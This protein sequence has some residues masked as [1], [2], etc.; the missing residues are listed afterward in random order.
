MIN[1]D[2]LIASGDAERLIVHL[3]DLARLQAIAGGETPA[4]DDSGWSIVDVCLECLNANKVVIGIA[5][6]E[7]AERVILNGYPRAH[8]LAPAATPEPQSAAFAKVVGRWLAARG[9]AVSDVRGDGNCFFRSIV[10]ALFHVATPCKESISGLEE[11]SLSLYLR[12][13][14]STMGIYRDYIADDDGEQLAMERSGVWADAVQVAKVSQYLEAPVHVVRC[15]DPGLKFD[16]DNGCITP[17]PLYQYGNN[18]DE[19]PLILL[20]D[21]YPV[22]KNNNMYVYMCMYN[23]IKWTKHFC[24]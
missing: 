16:S 10:R 6:A 2:N 9:W 1:L 11:D 5:T 3:T 23:E 12:K 15:D 20:Y 14:I 7:E 22:K 4:E 21:P 19:D 24:F 8:S 13:E 18:F 17:S